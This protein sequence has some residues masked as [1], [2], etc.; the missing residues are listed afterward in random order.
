MSSKVP[1]FSVGD[2]VTERFPSTRRRLPET[3]IVVQRYDLANEYRYVVKFA[4]GR[5]EVFY[6]REL[7]STEPSE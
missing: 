5:E 4:S 6:E 2:K 1:R 3:G 7:L